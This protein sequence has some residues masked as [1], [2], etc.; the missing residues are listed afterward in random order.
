M[1]DRVWP[2]VIGASHWWFNDTNSLNFSLHHCTSLASHW[3][4]WPNR[5][6]KRWPLIF[7]L[8]GVCRY[9]ALSFPHQR[10]IG[11]SVLLALMGMGTSHIIFDVMIIHAWFWWLCFMWCLFFLLQLCA[12]WRQWMRKLGKMESKLSALTSTDHMVVRS[13]Y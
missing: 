4:S 9:M 7:K 12:W 10:D 1:P 11:L 6:G 3:R 13:T 2:H 8:R 5:D